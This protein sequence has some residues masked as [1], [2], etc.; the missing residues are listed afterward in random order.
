M[1]TIDKTDYYK[2]KIKEKEDLL[3][4]WRTGTTSDLL[5]L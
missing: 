4:D 5:E 1:K 2:F 3:K